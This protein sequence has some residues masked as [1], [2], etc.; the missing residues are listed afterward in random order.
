MDLT[1]SVITAEKILALFIMLCFGAAGNKFGLLDKEREKMLS[2]L[3]INLIMPVTFFMSFQQEFDPAKFK[4]LL[5]TFGIAALAH[6]I[7]IAIGHFFYKESPDTQWEIDRY[8][9]TYGNCAFIGIPLIQNILGYEGVFY[10]TAFITVFNVLVFTHGVRLIGGSGVKIDLLHSIVLNP[11]FIGIGLG[12]VCYLCRFMLP[13]VIQDPLRT[14]ANC[15]TPIA[16]LVAGSALTGTDFRAILRSARTYTVSAVRLLITP[17][18]MVLIC[19]MLHI[20]QNVALST[21]ICAGAPVG[22]MATVLAVQ[23]DKDAAYSSGLFAFTT[24]I[25]IIT[26]PIVVAIY[27]LF[28]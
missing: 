24:I 10:V 15:N 22:T 6:L 28:I 4:G 27:S 25:C 12:L 19:T 11:I 21:I 9:C 5:I 20:E 2:N 3:L 17:V 1:L 8:C 18:I 7:P 23:Y 16:M 13:A 14:I 26:L